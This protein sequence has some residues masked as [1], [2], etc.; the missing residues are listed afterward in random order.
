MKGKEGEVDVGERGDRWKKWKERRLQ[1]ACIVWGKIKVTD[2][3]H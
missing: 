1:L 2:Q 3:H